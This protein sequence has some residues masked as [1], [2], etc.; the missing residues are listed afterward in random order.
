[1]N[2]VHE[3]KDLMGFTYRKT[4]QCEKCG[5]VVSKEAHSIA[6]DCCIKCKHEIQK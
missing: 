4:Y 5:H 6:P 1:M 3:D 2:L